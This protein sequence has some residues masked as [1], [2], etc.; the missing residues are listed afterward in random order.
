MHL[1][2]VIPPPLATP[3]HNPN[4]D[5]GDHQ[6]SRRV[7][8]KLCAGASSAENAS[9]RCQQT[10]RDVQKLLDSEGLTKYHFRKPQHITKATTSNDNASERPNP[11]LSPFAKM[12]L[13]S[14]DVPFRYLTPDSPGTQPSSAVNGSFKSSKPKA[15][16][17]VPTPQSNKTTPIQSNGFHPPSEVCLSQDFHPGPSSQVL[18]AVV[19]TALSASEMAGVPYIS[20]S[21]GQSNAKP[22]STAHSG[23]R[24]ISVDQRRQG[25]AAVAEL[26]Q[27]LDDIFAEDDN[28]DPHGME[29]SRILA[30][31]EG[32]EGRVSIL[33]VHV[34]DKLDAAFQSVTKFSRLDSLS[35]QDLIR[36]Q[37]F[38]ERAVS[39][40]NNLQLQIE[41]DWS[42]DDV[43]FWLSKLGQGVNGLLAARTLL[44]I[45]NAG[46][47]E[48][49]LQSEDHVRTVLDLLKMV[50]DTAIVPI[51]EERSFVGEKVRGGDKPQ[52]NPKFVLATNHRSALRALL[53]A[54]TK[55]LRLLANL[56]SKVDVD[57]SA[58]SSIVF[59]CKSLIF[60]E[61]ATTDK[62]SVLA[63]QPFESTRKYAMD[64][65]G[66]IFTRYTDQR[67]FVID[68][69]LVSLEKLPATKQSA[70]QYRLTDGKPIQ[71]VS[72]LLMR[73][74]QTSATRNSTAL[75][76]RSKADEDDDDEDAE[77][78]DEE[79]EDEDEEDDGYEE[80]KLSNN[81]RGAPKDL[82]S[83]YKPLYIAA[84]NNASH[85]VRILI[86]RASTTAKNSDEPF[87]KLMDIFTEDFLSV[88]GST[89]WPAAELLLRTM[90][91]SFII[92]SEDPK[93]SV[94]A[95]NLALE[96][97]GVMGSGILG[98]HMHTRNAVKN[99]DLEESSLINAMV[100]NFR[101][102]EANNK[103]L[104][105]SDLLGFTGPYRIV[106]EY[107]NARDTGNDAQLQTAKGF[108]LIQWAH[109]LCNNRAGSVDSENSDAPDFSQDMS[110]KLRSMIIDPQWLES[111]SEVK[112]PSTT[113][114]H[115]ASLL[116]TVN[117]TF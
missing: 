116:V 67:Q 44:R 63:V 39:A 114:G 112:T 86:N 21:G 87:R 55:T 69:I 33:Q 9:K 23:S 68:E 101:N 49:E 71:L 62:D 88:L 57:E 80:N 95:R 99:V 104:D 97:M 48:K 115:F 3:Y 12:V 45:M 7:L 110:N 98:L 15:H 37:K 96:L 31:A 61:N 106:L 84:Q 18:R 64:V 10:I 79:M 30:V 20:D 35:F 117:L 100:T 14:T 54:V 43:Q 26:Q 22:H 40:F 38:N 93:K 75:H 28:F 91:Q 70:R 66:R 90:L 11:A 4:F 25:D 83:V 111:I 46:R 60:A 59:M 6:R 42:E 77:G 65:L 27:Q 102:A 56:L 1:A 103:D 85:I 36:A 2:E 53:S 108:L 73:L 5:L 13:E 24:T 81:K 32:D 58:I 76:L 19:P 82:A 41:E 113:T 72:A 50:I 92:L 94:P 8:D 16:K 47:Q 29:T 52:H 34:Q 109:Q 51:V 107:L 17:E 78:S 74:V 105:S 89:D